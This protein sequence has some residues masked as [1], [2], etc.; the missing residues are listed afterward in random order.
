MSSEKLERFST[1]LDICYRDEDCFSKKCLHIRCFDDAG[2]VSSSMSLQNLTLC[3]D[4]E[5]EQDIAYN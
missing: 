3:C 2:S 4:L 5:T 1:Y